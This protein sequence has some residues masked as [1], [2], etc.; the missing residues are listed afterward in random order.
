MNLIHIRAWMG[1]SAPASEE[2]AQ[3]VNI[4]IKPSDPAGVLQ[5]EGVAVSGHHNRSYRPWS[6]D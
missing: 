5:R 4:K 3:G 1:G 2:A 6:W